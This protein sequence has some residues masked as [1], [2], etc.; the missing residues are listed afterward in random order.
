MKRPAGSYLKPLLPP[1][2]AHLN[3]D[4]FSVEL[5]ETSLDGFLQLYQAHLQEL[6][7]ETLTAPVYLP[8]FIFM[9]RPPSSYR[10]NKTETK[11]TT[12]LRVQRSLRAFREKQQG[13]DNES[14]PTIFQ[15][16]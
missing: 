12:R 14:Q 4:R 15:G 11:I 7:Q 9:Q 1:L 13:G 8:E 10:R 6:G 2:A 3:L 16:P 5:L